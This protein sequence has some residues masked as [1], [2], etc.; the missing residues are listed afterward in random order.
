MMMASKAD[1]M[2]IGSYYP[3]GAAPYSRC[4]PSGGIPTIS[5]ARLTMTPVLAI[6]LRGRID[7]PFHFDTGP[8]S[9]SLR[10]E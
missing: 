7:H 4:T 1:L 8:F 9:V 3:K 10:E 2:S 5:I 6:Q